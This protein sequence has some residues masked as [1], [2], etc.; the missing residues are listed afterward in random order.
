LRQISDEQDLSRLLM[1]LKMM[2]PSYNPSSLLL[3]SALLAPSRHGEPARFLVAGEEPED[4]LATEFSPSI[5]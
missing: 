4:L 2:I 3:R 1:L 5:Q